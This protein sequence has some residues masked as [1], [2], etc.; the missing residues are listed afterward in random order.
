MVK[1]EKISDLLEVAV[2]IER[3][4][5]DFYLALSKS[6]E[7]SRARGVFSFLASEEEKHIGVFRK[8]LEETADYTP[9]FSY[10]GEY[11]LFLEGI[12][13]RSV[14][15]QQKMQ[16]KKIT[17]AQNIPETIEIAMNFET[18]SILFYNELLSVFENTDRKYLNEV[19]KEEKSHF[20]KLVNIKDELKF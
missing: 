10:P 11:E 7:D 9:R 4:G 19:I 14:F 15:T 5:R 12:A 8:M 16:D 20:V 17:S 13:S 2:R 18:E 1:I 6:A 3:I